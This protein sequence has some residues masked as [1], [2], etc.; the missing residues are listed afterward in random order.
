MI[1]MYPVDMPDMRTIFGIKLCPFPTCYICIHCSLFQHQ[2]R[3]TATIKY[4]DLSTQCMT[5][6]KCQLLDK[7]KSNFMV[8]MYCDIM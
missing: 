8:V 2:K 5:K 6:H 1:N 4:H 3:A 7:A